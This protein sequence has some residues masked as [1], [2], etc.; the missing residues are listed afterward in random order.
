MIAG[1]GLVRD[2]ADVI[3]SL[4]DH[5]FGEGIDKLFITLHR[6]A[7]GTAEILEAIQRA[8]PGRLHLTHVY[9]A[10]YEQELWMNN[11]AAR[12]AS[13]GATWIVPFDGDE[14]WQAVC[15]G[16]GGVA[17]VLHSTTADVV[18][19]TIWPMDPNGDGTFRQRATPEELVKVAFRPHPAARLSM[20]NHSV[21]HP[22]TVTDG[23]EI[24]HYQ[25]RSLDHLRRKVRDGTEA[26][27]A[28][29]SSGGG[30]WRALDELS[31]DELGQ[32]WEWLCRA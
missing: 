9:S 23:L 4:V 11:G 3:E 31:D 12:A 19:A 13:E 10:P 6:S 28:Q 29:G 21:S 24:L 15:A 18:N 5:L 27:R 16:C 14:F 26:L 1:V 22:G 32:V 7:D 25:W 20:G 17:E 8:N 2:E 30:H